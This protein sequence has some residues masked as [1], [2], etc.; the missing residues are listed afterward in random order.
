[1]IAIFLKHAIR[2]LLRSWEGIQ[3]EK[4][5]LKESHLCINLLKIKKYQ[6]AKLNLSSVS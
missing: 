5:D 4:T 1:M 2:S 6:K 3:S